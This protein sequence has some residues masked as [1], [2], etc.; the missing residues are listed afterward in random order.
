MYGVQRGAIAIA[1]LL[2]SFVDQGTLGSQLRGLNQHLLDVLVRVNA[3][4]S[5]RLPNIS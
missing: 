5:H 2:F 3:L 1:L 4:A